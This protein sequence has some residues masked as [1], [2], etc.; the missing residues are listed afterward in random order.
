MPKDYFVLRGDPP[1]TVDYP[2]GFYELE[3]AQ[4]YAHDRAVTDVGVRYTVVSQVEA[5]EVEPAKI[6]L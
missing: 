3:T 1:E 5:Y 2:P 6:T 4:K